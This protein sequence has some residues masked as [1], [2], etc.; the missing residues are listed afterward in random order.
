MTPDDQRAFE[1][2]SRWI[3]EQLDHRWREIAE[4]RGVA[5]D[6]SSYGARTKLVDARLA[7]LRRRRAGGSTAG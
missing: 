2:R 3:D 1:E 7:E 6:A 5:F 4:R